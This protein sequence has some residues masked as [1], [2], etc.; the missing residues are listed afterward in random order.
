MQIDDRVSDADAQAVERGLLAFNEQ[1]LGPSNEL[2]V[3]AVVRAP[4]GSVVGGLLGH[5][6][7]G[8]LYVA[9]L[10]VAEAQRGKGLGYRLFGTLEGYPP[11]YRQH[12]LSKPL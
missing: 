8:W 3:R 6:R 2:P 11:G 5:T 1:R 9:K 4:G 12:Y 10:W 7:W